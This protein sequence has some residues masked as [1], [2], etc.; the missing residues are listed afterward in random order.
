MTFFSTTV[1]PELVDVVVLVVVEVSPPDVV[2]DDV[3]EV[4]E[5]VDD[6]VELE[7][8]LVVGGEV[9]ESLPPPQATNPAHK[10]NASALCWIT[11]A[12]L[13]YNPPVIKFIT[14]RYQRLIT[15]LVTLLP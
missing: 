9:V 5:V 4:L 14:V 10:M 15:N 8:V 6:V 7:V 2:D 3:L 13:I 11:L 12:C 1:P